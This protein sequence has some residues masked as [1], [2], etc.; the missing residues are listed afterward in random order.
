[1]VEA[2]IPVQIQKKSS[3]Q[4]GKRKNVKTPALSEVVPNSQR[5]KPRLPHTTCC[6]KSEAPQP[7]SASKKGKM[8]LE[9]LLESEKLKVLPIIILRLEY[10][11]SYVSDF[12]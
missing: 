3:F 9:A 10:F 2:E 1:M 6:S 5:G 8:V 11:F 4:K 12:I 7:E